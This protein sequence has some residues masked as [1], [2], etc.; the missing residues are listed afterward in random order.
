MALPGKQREIE[1]RPL[2]TPAP[3]EVERPIR[4]EP[5]PDLPAP[6]EPERLPEKVPEPEKV[7]A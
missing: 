3:R 2:E 4:V 1:V 7:P 5:M 6:K